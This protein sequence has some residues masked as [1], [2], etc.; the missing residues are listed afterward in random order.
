MIEQIRV[1]TEERVLLLTPDI[2]Y[3]QRRE[4]CGAACR[5]LSLSLI[6]NRHF[7]P[8]DPQDRPPLIVWICGGGFSEQ[9]RN[10]WVP[11]L[12]YY[13]RRGYAVALVDYSVNQRVR[14]PQ[15]LVDVKEAIRYLR[16][17]ADELAID[18]SRV[19]VMGESA[20]GY[21]AALAGLT[22][23][24]EAFDVGGNPDRSSDVQAV[25]PFYTPVDVHV[26]SVEAA[27]GRP[28]LTAEVVNTLPNL[29]D[30][31]RP[32]CPPFLMFHGLADGIVSCEG[33][34]A[35]H[36]ALAARGNAVD[37]CLIEGAN[38]GD[39]HFIQ[40][41]I[42]DRVIEFLKRHGIAPAQP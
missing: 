23:G 34:R 31:V 19:A 41:Q 32:D 16:A 42:K 28:M 36:D 13:A 33:S 14:Y 35:L 38:H 6:R 8:Y 18:A 5:Q 2:V 10:V 26:D 30:L 17:H 1:P 7:Y 27:K 25:V 29:L 15:Q 12:S 9:N 21:L 24:M 40:P 22:N 11:E 20:G 4:W 39:C 37:L 3:A